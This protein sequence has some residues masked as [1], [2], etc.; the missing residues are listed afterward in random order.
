MADERAWIM[1][2]KG[3]NTFSWSTT[4]RL[5]FKPSIINK[6]KSPANITK[7]RGEYLLL[8]KQDFECLWTE[9]SKP[10]YPLPNSNDRFALFPK[11]SF[12]RPFFIDRSFDMKDSDAISS[13]D[14]VLFFRARVD[15]EDVFKKH[16]FTTAAYRYVPITMPPPRGFQQD[17]PPAYNQAVLKAEGS[18]S[19]GPTCLFVQ[20]LIGTL[21]ST[22]SA[23]CLRLGLSDRVGHRA[24]SSGCRRGRRSAAPLQAFLHS[25]GNS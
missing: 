14:L 18:G 5:E 17:G 24:S 11:D 3:Q 2:S 22:G 25:P 7:V 12:T 8:S 6:G 1:V 23:P 13:G 20:A 10:E 9:K 19:D 16:R 15:Y 21:V 4:S